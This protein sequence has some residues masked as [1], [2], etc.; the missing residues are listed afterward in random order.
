MGD[1]KKAVLKLSIPMIIAMI[2]NSLYAFIDG[3]WVAGLGDASLAA[4]GFVNPLYLIVF[5]VS[6]GIGAGATAVISRY[7]GSKNKKEADNAALHVILLTIIITIIFTA[8]ILIFLKPILLTMGAG[9]TINL[10]MEYGNILFLGTIFIVFSA[11]AYG[12]LRAEGNV[13]KTTY[14]M[15]FGAILNMFLDPI[16]IYYLDLGV[17]GA[18][19]ATVISMGLVS[20]LLLYWFKGDTYIKF[21]LKDFIYKS[22][23]IKEILSVGL[24]AGV[25]FFLI[26][27]L[28]I[29]LNAIL[30]IVSGVDGVAVYTGGWRFV[31]IVMVIP[32]AIGT[33]VIAITGAN[34][35]AKRY[36]NIDITHSYAIKFGTL[37]I[38]ILSIAIFILAP[39][40]SYLF[41]YT[42]GSEN[43]LGQ[44]TDFL[45]ITCL[46]YLFFPLGVVS[47]SVFQGLGKGLNSLIIAFIRA[48]I[49]QIVFS[50]VFAIVLNLGQTGVWYGIVLGNAIG[51]IIAYIWSKIYIS[52]LSNEDEKFC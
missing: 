18:A 25:E 44:M 50:Y 11:T 2:I 14:A 26:S 1:P 17:A 30:M 8:L 41:A 12:I 52:K 21:S 49:L 15:L 37:I 35:G 31:A 32:I 9:P 10:G 43:L 34:L 38:V 29:T 7:I 22:K 19:I 47:S 13:I 5:G 45:R 4:I 42:P 28:A 16:F 46:F 48:L 33:S 40:I 27:V 3:V 24:P 20:L 23:L 6:N 39:Y 36:E 51:A